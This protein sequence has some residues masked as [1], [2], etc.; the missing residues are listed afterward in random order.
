M[1]ADVSAFV[2]GCLHCM[3]TANGCVPRP[4][5][6]TLVATKPNEVLHF[7]FLTMIEGERGLKYVL[8]LKDGMSG[9]VELVACVSATSDQAYQS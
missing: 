7:D 2:A 1:A 9:F 4:Y 3:V 5:G 8:V 6:E